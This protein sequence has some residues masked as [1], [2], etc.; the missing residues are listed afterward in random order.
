MKVIRDIRQS[1]NWSNYLASLGWKAFKTSSG[2]IAEYR[3]TPFGKIVK[4]QRPVNITPKDI[5]EIENKLDKLLFIKIE[6]YQKVNLATCG[7]TNSESPLLPPSTIYVDL[8]LGKE[9]LKKSMSRSARYSINKAARDGDIVDIY[10]NPSNDALKK[11]HTLLRETGRRNHFYVQPFDD[12]T[13]KRDLFNQESF[14]ITVKDKKNNLIGG[15]FYLG[16]AGTIWALHIAT[17]SFRKASKGGYLLVG[18]AI[19]Y[20]KHLGYTTM[21]ME[22]VQ[23]KRFL[24]FTKHWGGF[25]EFKSRFG[26][27]VIEM[28]HP[29]IKIY[30]PLFKVLT[31]LPKVSF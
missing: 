24:V 15:N 4:I 9:E 28:P 6:P 17:G 2:V 8:E 22:G 12:L 14:L 7:F 19:P 21:D 20:F 5:E 26:G 27:E 25:T 10:Q 18:T 13:T 31:S 11:F 30:N 23:D 16:H 29:L 1:D 3:N